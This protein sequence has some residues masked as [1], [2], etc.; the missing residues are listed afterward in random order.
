MGE[1]G[2][3]IEVVYATPDQQWLVNLDLPATATVEDAISGALAAG[4]PAID[5]SHLPVGIWGRLVERTQRLKNGDRVELYR[6]LLRDPRE[7]RRNLAAAGK[8][9]N[10]S[11]RKGSG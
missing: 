6:P 7:A 8:S 5:V 1:P 11:G 3:N 10:T 4:F 2:L 9:M